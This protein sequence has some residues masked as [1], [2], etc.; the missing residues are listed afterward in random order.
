M[1]K[2][3]Y[4]KES[5]TIEEENEERYIEYSLL[6]K[7]TPFEGSGINY[8]S[9]GVEINMSDKNKLIETARA[10]DL[11]F[12][13]EKAVEFIDGLKSGLVTPCTLDDIVED[14]LRGALMDS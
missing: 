14:T 2:E 7:E 12:S 5:I 4:G 1:K 6:I 9:Y 11:F 13:K 8:L 10:E 3:L